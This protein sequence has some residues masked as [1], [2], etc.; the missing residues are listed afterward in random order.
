[1]KKIIKFIQNHKENLRQLDTMLAYK[2]K[3]G[4]KGME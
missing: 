1:M 2:S 3:L 4:E